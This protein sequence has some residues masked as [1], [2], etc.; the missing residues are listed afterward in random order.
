M[1]RSAKVELVVRVTELSKKLALKLRHRR[2]THCKATRVH[3][4]SPPS[5][6]FSTQHGCSEST[7][8]ILI[9]VVKYCKVTIQRKQPIAQRASVSI[10]LCRFVSFQCST[11]LYT[12]LYMWHYCRGLLHLKLLC[13]LLLSLSLRC[14]GLVC[15]SRR[16][17]L[18]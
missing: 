1:P 18:C 11:L 6:R 14:H 7:L 9:I 12:L 15:I 16:T 5:Q 4:A 17:Q 8:C 10:K 13:R 2:A 3:L